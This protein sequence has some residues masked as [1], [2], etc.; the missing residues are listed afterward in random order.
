MTLTR[1]K[2]KY[3]TKH[4]P[5]VISSNINSID[6]MGQNVVRRS[7]KSDSNCPGHGKDL[8]Q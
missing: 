4:C 1:K 2:T 8:S 6:N 5:S 3:K 7:E